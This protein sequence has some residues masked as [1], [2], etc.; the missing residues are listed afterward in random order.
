ME[1][2]SATAHRPLG[3]GREINSLDYPRSRRP[4]R[5]LATVRRQ[6]AFSE[7]GKD[8]PA[9]AVEDT[10]SPRYGLASAT[11]R[12]SN[13]FVRCIDD[14]HMSIMPHI[15]ATAQLGRAPLLDTAAGVLLQIHRH[16]CPV[17]RT[18]TDNVSVL[19]GYAKALRLARLAISS[20]KLQ[21]TDETLAGISLMA[22][23]DCLLQAH[24]A[25]YGG[26]FGHWGGLTGLLL[27]RPQATYQ[28]PAVRANVYSAGLLTFVI[29]AFTGQDS[30]FEADHW[31]QAEP[32][33]LHTEPAHLSRLRKA[34]QRMAILL[35]RLLRLVRETSVVSADTD[36]RAEAVMLA[37]ALML[38]EDKEAESWILHRVRVVTTRDTGDKIITPISYEWPNLEELDAAVCYWQVL[39]VLLR[40]RSVLGL[41]NTS[42]QNS[43]E[44]HSHISALSEKQHKNLESEQ[45]RLCT[46]IMMSW[47]QASINAPCGTM[48][49][50][51]AHIAVWTVLRRQR[52][53]R[54]VP[55]DVV[56][57]WL[58]KAFEKSWRGT[59]R[60]HTMA[61]FDTMST[62]LEGGPLSGML[63][64]LMESKRSIKDTIAP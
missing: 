55:R 20:P 22:G 14:F 30:P 4:T 50:T 60:A 11:V 33:S 37:D 24:G 31:L 46:N 36:K 51:T 41:C 6:Q 47:Q 25:S 29:P 61:E 32:A 12:L 15:F 52:C 13:E 17:T 53:Y 9:T 59:A 54:N 10:P 48:S 26:A 62:V 27:A 56:G 40:L 45:L 64:S 5:D 49:L 3:Q 39:L 16:S 57:A 42:P 43:T 35:P 38:L 2:L 8:S 19:H 21:F 7:N 44:P 18:I 34:G 28:S 23:I 63:L 1:A 58:H